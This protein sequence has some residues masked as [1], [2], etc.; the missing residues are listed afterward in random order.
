MSLTQQIIDFAIRVGQELKSKQEKLISGNNIKTV[1]SQS[2]LGSGNIIIEGAIGEGNVVNN[3]ISLLYSDE[4]NS[5][6]NANS[7]AESGALKTY[8]IAPNSYNK[9]KIEI[10]VRA[11]VE[12]DATTKSDFTW[13][14]KSGESTVQT[15]VQRI[16][17]NSA[18]GS[19]S[20]GRMTETLSF[21]IDGGQI[22]DT[23]IT[24]TVQN[25]LSNANTGALIHAFRVYAIDD[26]QVG[27]GPEGLSGENGADAYEVAVAE[28]FSGTRAE[29]L[30]S[31]VGDPAGDGYMTYAKMAT[32][33]T[34]RQTVAASNIDWSTG[35]IFVKTLTQ[36]TTFTFSNVQLNK[37][38]TL[39]VSG[40]YAFSI[41]VPAANILGIAN[42]AK[43]NKIQIQCTNSTSGSEE[44][45]ATITT[46]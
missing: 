33:L 45:W 39:I 15:F 26:V 16:I 22:I 14:I 21:I 23:D 44:F 25:S 41:P 17:A 4:T 11:R 34:S 32:D 36:S 30:A 12:Q 27:S 13:R 38:I 19:D 29:W 8:T 2:L 46:N 6:E 31:L 10:V 28:G 3:L 9:I 7:T 5:S 37:V 24:V 43:T 1:N 18:T 20:G 40:A 42:T 35:G